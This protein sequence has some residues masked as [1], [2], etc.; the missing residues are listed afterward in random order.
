MP[1]FLDPA[2]LAVRRVAESLGDLRDD[3]VFL[4]GAVVPLLTTDPA[5]G[6]FRPTDDVD[7]VTE[8]ISRVEHGALEAGLRDR[9]F[10]H[11]T[12]PGAPICRWRLG[13]LIVDAMPQDSAVLG[14]GNPWYSA[15]L[16][17]SW[18][19]TFPDGLTV[20]IVAAPVFFATKWEAFNDR[21][22]GCD[23]AG[24]HDLEDILTILDTRAELTGEI[25]ASPTEVRM[26]VA[27][28]AASMTADATF[29]N[30]LPGLVESGRDDVVL[31]RLQRIAALAEP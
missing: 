29:L 30:V 3:G 21:G 28:A 25:Q 27:Q 5:A 22:K 15:A 14:F 26:A 1:D 20:R 19:L 2:A 10:T 24:S 18:R 17:T 7:F 12:T 4:G 23:F 9:G 13:D 8:A 11:D 16:A 31:D 6:G